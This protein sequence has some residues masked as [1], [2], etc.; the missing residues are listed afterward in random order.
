MSTPSKC[1]QCGEPVMTGEQNALARR[2]FAV[3]DRAHNLGVDLNVDL[4][5]YFAA[6]H[7]VK[8]LEVG[9]EKYPSASAIID[10]VACELTADVQKDIENSEVGLFMTI[11][12]LNDI[13]YEYRSICRSIGL[14]AVKGVTAPDTRAPADQPAKDNTGTI[15][16]GVIGVAVFTDPRKTIAKVKNDSGAAFVP[17]SDPSASPLASTSLSASAIAAAVETSGAK[18]ANTIA[19]GFAPAS[20]AAAVLTDPAY[21][22]SNASAPVYNAVHNKPV[23]IEKPKSWHHAKYQAHH[24]KRLA[25]IGITIFNNT[26]LHPGCIIAHFTVDVTKTH[27]NDWATQLCRITEAMGRRAALLYTYYFK[28]GEERLKCTMMAAEHPKNKFC[29]TVLTGGYD[30]KLEFVAD[31]GQGG[32][33][34]RCISPGRYYCVDSKHACPVKGTLYV[35]GQAPCALVACDVSMI[36]VI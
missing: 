1:Q 32:T 11:E 22:C 21:K 9:V 33:S 13:Q 27:K 4:E 2:M 25:D 17:D 20:A 7:L 34:V 19:K 18:L 16:P 3:K 30:D 12:D 26:E 6:L 28:R 8:H 14:A 5:A 24:L 10:K 23:D 29:W 35:D 15:P 36:C 31:N